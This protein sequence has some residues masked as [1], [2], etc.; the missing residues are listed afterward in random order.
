MLQCP[1]FLPVSGEFSFDIPGVFWTF[2]NSK[3]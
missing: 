1:R 2:Q 3:A